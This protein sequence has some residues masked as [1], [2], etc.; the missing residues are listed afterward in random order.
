V[1]WIGL[2]GEVEL[3]QNLQSAVLRGTNA[4]GAVESRA[5]HP[6]LTLGRVITK[7]RD[8][9]ARIG[10]AVQE[11]RMQSTCPWR[12]ASVRLIQSELASGGSRYTSLACFPLHGTTA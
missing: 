6:H 4:W 3:L 9:L 8:E 5:F 7:R 10:V 11:I 1:I 12:V 2:E